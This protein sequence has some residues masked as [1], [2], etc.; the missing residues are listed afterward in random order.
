MADWSRLHEHVLALIIRRVTNLS[1]H[2]RVSGVCSSWRAIAKQNR[3]YLLG[4][5]IP[6]LMISG[7]LGNCNQETR[8]FLIFP[9]N[10]ERKTVPPLLYVPH[11]H[12]CCGSHQGWLALLDEDMGMYL[13]NPLAQKRR[14]LPTLAFLQTAYMR[15]L[16]VDKAVMSSTPSSSN[17]V[18]L[19]FYGRCGLAFC[20]LGDKSWTN[21]D[22]G[23]S[24]GFSDGLY[25]KGRFY[26]VDDFGRI[27]ACDTNA[28]TRSLEEFE[29]QPGE[30]K[31]RNK[32]YLVDLEGELYRVLRKFDVSEKF[33]YGDTSSDDDDDE[34]EDEN[35]GI[36]GLVST[37]KFRLWKLDL[38]KKRWISVQDLADYAVF[39]GYNN[40][41]S[42]SV[43]DVVG[44]RGNCIY[45]TDDRL[46]KHFGFTWRGHDMGVFYLKDSTMAPLY[47][48]QSEWVKLP[49]AIWF[50][51]LPW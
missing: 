1:D 18:V 16:N 24:N 47:W 11:R 37:R 43:F 26:V 28:S 14:R 2:I 8:Q 20:R 32:W 25:L 12:K 36:M 27:Y 29:Y 19:I 48:T 3:H 10:F 46:S 30:T 9:E 51:P 6:G 39:L 49:P 38:S 5:Q 35:T 31:Y 15:F 45:F 40:S 50:I 34:E 17:C 7:T 42:L 13:L 21:I 41:I 22:H 23:S 33:Y 44:V 4:H